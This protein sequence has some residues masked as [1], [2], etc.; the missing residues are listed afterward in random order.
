MGTPANALRPLLLLALTLALLGGGL[1]FFRLGPWP[2]AGDELATLTEADSLFG[3]TVSPPESQTYRL[4]RLV[5]LSY[6]IHYADYQL[7][8]RD[9]WG[10][11][12]LIALLG[13][14][15]IVLVFICL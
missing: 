4:A 11:R 7:F 1:R 3:K 6:A 8:G 14:L 2:F 9:E 10:S 15:Q 13:T 12:V 5:P